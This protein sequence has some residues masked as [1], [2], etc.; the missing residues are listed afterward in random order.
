MMRFQQQAAISDGAAKSYDESLGD[1][2]SAALHDVTPNA[3]PL[4]TFALWLQEGKLN[5]APQYQRGYVWKVEKASR[6]VVT[7]LCRRIVPAVT[8]CEVDDGVFDVVD[9]KQ[10]LS[11][12]LSFFLAGKNPSLHSTLIREGK[13]PT[14]FTTLSKLDENYESLNGLNYSLLSKKRQNSFSMFK[15]PVTTIPQTT[16]RQHVF[17]CYEDINS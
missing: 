17:S 8:M 12:L 13:L 3:L 16:P 6:L 5:L 4:D 10:R 1:F 2:E 14:D 9:G 11:T 15:I 7:V